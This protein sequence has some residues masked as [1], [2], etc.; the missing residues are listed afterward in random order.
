MLL[1][2]GGLLPHRAALVPLDLLVRSREPVLDLVNS[3][4]PSR[5]LPY[6]RSLP[7]P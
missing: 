6:S 7:P 5:K 4:A 1:A 2:C 3:L